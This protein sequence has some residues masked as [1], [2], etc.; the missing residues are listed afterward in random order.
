MYVI[1][2]MKY[3]CSHYSL[4][5]NFNCKLLNI[6]G[7]AGVSFRTARLAFA[8]KIDCGSIILF[9]ILEVETPKY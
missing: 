2:F 6:R 9:D 4:C 1:M 8:E 5:Q 3:L 7:A